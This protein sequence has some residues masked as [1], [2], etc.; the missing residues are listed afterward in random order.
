MFLLYH[1]INVL[2]NENIRSVPEVML[3]SELAPDKF[4]NVCK[5]FPNI[6]IL[7]K[8]S[9]P[10]EIQLTFGHAAVGNK[11]LGEYIVAF[12]L[13]GDLISTSETLFNVEIA[14]AADSEEIDPPIAEVLL[15]AA[16]GD[17]A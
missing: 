1:Y 7:T 17:L 16:A 6:A 14:F 3:A 10:G 5:D 8:S 15:R 13:A 12:A 9:K 11:S 2:V 4:K